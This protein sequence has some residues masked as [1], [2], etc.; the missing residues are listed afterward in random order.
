[1]LRLARRAGCV[2]LAT[3]AAASTLSC[4]P[5]QQLSLRSTL[6]LR[7]GI[8]MPNFGL[9]TYLSKPGDC[10][11][12]V[13]AAL[14]HGYTLID[15]AAMYAN[16]NDVGDALRASSKE[17]I[18]VVSKLM[19]EDHGREKTLAAIDLTLEKLG[20]EQLDLWLM[21]TPSGGRVVETWQAMLEAR[22][23]GKCRGASQ[24][25]VIP[26]VGKSPPLRVCP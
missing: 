14:A 22:D 11:K 21:H 24:T 9:G 20:V 13:T 7:S 2:S 6:R 19:P 25:V 15:T 18:F 3:F 10:F 1:M 16:E 17:H 23:S 12:A 8:E 26:T 5:S 4:E